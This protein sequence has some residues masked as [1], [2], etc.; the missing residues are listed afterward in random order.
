VKYSRTP[1]AGV[2]LRDFLFEAVA[3]AFIL[4]AA[5]V[6]GCLIASNLEGRIAHH[7]AVDLQ[8]ALQ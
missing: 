8:R 6:A 1:M 4:I 3:I 5:A 7:C 2:N